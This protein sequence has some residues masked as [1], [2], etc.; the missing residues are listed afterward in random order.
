MASPFTFFRK[1]QKALLAIATV[2][3]VFIF[4]V[5]SALDPGQSGRSDGSGQQVATWNGGE[6]NAGQLENLLRNRRLTAMFTQMM[7]GAGI[8]AG[9]TVEELQLPQDL[10]NQLLLGE[11]ITQA[12][13]ERLVLT[14]Q[15]YSDAAEQAGIRV[16]S[17]VIN[18]VINRLGSER[19][20]SSDV[21]NVLA[22]ISRGDAQAAE[23]VV[24]STLRRVLQAYIYQNSYGDAAATILPAQQWDAWRRINEQIS[25]QAAIV[26]TA[27]LVTESPQPTDQQ[28]TEY[29]EQYKDVEPDQMVRVGG[30]IMPSPNPGFAKPR[31]VKLAFLHGSVTDWTEKLLP[32]VTEQ[33]I[34]D[35]YEVNKNPQFI[36]DEADD[37]VE[38]PESDP[39]D[40]VEA[41]EATE[42][43]DEEAAAPAEPAA[44]DAEPA[45]DEPMREEVG[46]DEE[47]VAESTEEAAEAD[48]P[49]ADSEAA[50]PTAESEATEDADDDEGASATRPSPF[51]LAAFQAE[52]ESRY[53]EE[54]GDDDESAA[55][56]DDASDA[57]A[58]ETAG[59]DE[60]MPADDEAAPAD[61]ETGDDAMSDEDAAA[62]EVATSDEDAEGEE[63]EV[64][65]YPLDEVRD[66]IR[67]EV[68]RVKAIERVQSEL[69]NAYETLRTQYSKHRRAVAT[70]MEE[71]QDAPE[72]PAELTNLEPLAERYGVTAETTPELTQRE[73]YQDTMVGQAIE[74]D[75]RAEVV[76]QAAFSHLEVG[77]PYFAVEAMGDC[78]LVV[79]VKD[80]PREVPELEDVRDQV[81]AAWRENEAAELALKKAEELAG[82][83]ADADRSFAELMADAGYR[84]IPQT[85][86]FS[87]MSFGLAA[88]DSYQLQISDVPG[89]DNVGSEFMEKV[90]SL[91]DDET[92]AIM[93][94]DRSAAY[95]VKIHSR[96]QTSDELREA[97]LRTGWNTR[98]PRIGGVLQML[99]RSSTQELIR[100][101]SERLQFQLNEEWRDRRLEQMQEQ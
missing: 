43:D 24:F 5:G 35:Y 19:L 89:L 9:G 21:R 6:V 1:R 18:E 68:A 60:E 77:E 25:L 12:E 86:P 36:K 96:E 29:Y 45:D 50:E 99:Q 47:D 70:A 74:P 34:S 49:A 88:D 26:P 32:E 22:T 8:Q 66:E 53:D 33:E 62:D 31:K 84:V 37:E 83:V 92:A 52:G 57:D 72:L 17:D 38:F 55:E 28:V 10:A 80:T 69:R 59:D 16:D 13:L 61:D 20:N 101:L 79:K 51:R 39:D 41:D 14:T 63:D 44:D 97:F 15:A 78:Y 91:K 4:V 42:S 11:R 93:N 85:D 54:V 67:R 23:G 46:D 94:I 87:W 56:S 64:E 95:V 65:Y 76:A 7:I 2:F 75:R 90:F 3:I 30:R 73:L 27:S 71:E 82:K 40:D 48:E 98:D 58:A 100:G 81:V